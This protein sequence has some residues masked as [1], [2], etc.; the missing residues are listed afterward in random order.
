M[1]LGDWSEA[2]RAVAFGIA[3]AVAA[4]GLLWTAS[5]LNRAPAASSGEPI[6]VQMRIDGASATIWY[7]ATTRNATVF[8]FLLEA[9]SIRGFEVTWSTWGPPLDAVF[10]ESIAGDVNGEGSRYWRFWIDGVYSA[11][12]ADHAG[13]QDGAFVEWRFQPGGGG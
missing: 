6:G 13:L 11:V 3:V 12:G 7:N 2:R 4:S 9:A 10:V 1:G 5:N 8:A